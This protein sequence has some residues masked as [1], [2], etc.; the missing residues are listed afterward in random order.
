MLP[1]LFT[2]ATITFIGS[3]GNFFA[4]YILLQTVNKLPSSVMIYQFFGQHTIV[5]GQLAAYFVMYMAPAFIL[6]ALHKL[7]CHRVLQCVAV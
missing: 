7:T 5:Y 1:G 4:P 3:W 6:I 2:V